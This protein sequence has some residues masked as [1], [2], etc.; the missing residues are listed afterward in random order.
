MKVMKLLSL[1][2]ILVML[3]VAHCSEFISFPYVVI[4]G[5]TFSSILKQFVLDSSIIN[6]KTPLVKKMISSNPQ[7]ED[8]ADLKVGVE[9]EVFISNEFLDNDKF[10]SYK[11]VLEKLKQEKEQKRL[12][13]ENKI[14]LEQLRIRQEKLEEFSSTNNDNANLKLRASAFLMSSIG[15]FTQ[16][17]ASYAE[18]SYHQ[19]SPISLGGAF[20]LPLR[21]KKIWVSGSLYYSKLHDLNNDLTNK[22]VS[23]P[24]E[25]GGNIYGE[26]HFDQYNFNAYTGFDYDHFSAF[27]L[28]GISLSNNIFIDQVQL[29][30]LTLGISKSFMIFN[31]K[32]FSKIALSPTVLSTYKDSYSSNNSTSTKYSGIRYLFYLKYDLNEKFYIHSL[33]QTFTSHEARPRRAADPG[34]CGGAH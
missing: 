34:L 18:I 31:Q 24:A 6:A 28:K 4:E 30:Y 23:V 16:K 14:A 27:N 13:E 19:D 2:F 15:T 10:N 22:S 26:Y 12:E 1:I 29:G 3:S 25:V 9:I 33:I 21:D 11:S 17:S 8:W 32:F 7:V 20:S 5:D